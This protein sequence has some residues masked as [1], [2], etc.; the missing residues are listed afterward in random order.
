[1]FWI[2]LAITIVGLA[3]VIAHYRLGKHA[4][5][6]AAGRTEEV[7]LKEIEALREHRS[8]LTKAIG[9]RTLSDHTKS[10]AGQELRRFS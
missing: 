4:L 9:D 1:M 5:A 8:R 7:Q 2:A 10:V 3:A 6:L